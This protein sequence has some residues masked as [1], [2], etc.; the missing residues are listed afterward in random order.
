MEKH[1]LSKTT[2]IKGMQ[3]EKAFYLNKYHKELKTEVNTAQQAIF[4][5]GTKVGELA[6]QLFNGQLA[7]KLNLRLLIR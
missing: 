2:F 3:C 1:V 7:Q 6:T 5:R 4:D